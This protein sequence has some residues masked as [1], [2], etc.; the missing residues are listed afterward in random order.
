MEQET[1]SVLQALAQRHTG[2][3][4]HHNKH[5]L[6]ASRLTAMAYRTG[7]DTVDDL[8]RYIGEFRPGSNIELE[9]ATALLDT[10]SRFVSERTELEPL[11]ETILLPALEHSG[12]DTYRIWCAGCGTGQ[13][14]FSLL[15]MLYNTLPAE[16]AQRVDIIAT[17][18]SEPALTRASSGVY[19]H[20]EVQTGLTAQNLIRYFTKVSE[21]TWQVSPILA[22]QVR[23]QAHNLLSPD[24]APGQ[25]DL[26][27]CRHVLTGMTPAHREQAQQSLTRHLHPEGHVH[28]IE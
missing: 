17:D 26:I 28:I 10:R 16:T 12:P 6:L 5:A 2:Q 14:A 18:I 9:V 22:R 4:L 3:F 20:F 19:T 11:F 1:F 15:M 13:E 8:A 25:F 7:H 24:D 27:L 21:R 23:F